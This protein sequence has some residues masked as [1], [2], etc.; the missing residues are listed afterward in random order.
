MASPVRV[1]VKDLGVHFGQHHV[2]KGLNIDIRESEFLVLLGSSGCGKST[3]LNAI[4][5]LID[6][7]EGEIQIGERDVTHAEPKDRGIAMVFQSYALYPRMNVRDNMTFGSRV[8]GVPKIEI[9]KRLDHAAKMLHLTELLDRRPAELSGGQRQ[10]VAIGRAVVRQ[11]GVFLFDEPLSNLDAQL[12]S[13]LRVEIKRLHQRLNATMIYVTHDQVEAMTLADRVAVMQAGVIQ[14]LDS[15]D[16]IYREPANRYVASFVGSPGMNFIEGRVRRRHGGGSY[17]AADQGFD[18][19]LDDRAASVLEGHPV[20]LGIRPE[21]ICSGAD[22]ESATA[23]RVSVEMLD[24]MGA[25]TYAW[26]CHFSGL[27]FRVRIRS[28]SDVQTGDLLPVLFPENAIS[29]FD[30]D[31]GARL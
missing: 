3:L 30:K 29:L 10:R 19:V 26:C 25:D 17:F 2:L 8:A 16:K 9:K 6:I 28:D 1:Q 11:S 21:Q 5:G 13:E 14:Q 20:V 15:P 27:S 18:V 7:Q 23:I 24:K 22:A 12:R 31:S 4:A